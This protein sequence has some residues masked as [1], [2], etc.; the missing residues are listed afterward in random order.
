MAAE[1]C[2]PLRLCEK[3]SENCLR[4]CAPL[5]LCVFA[6]LR[7]CD[8]ATC[9]LLINHLDNIFHDDIVFCENWFVDDARTF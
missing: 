9:D 2:A 7:L 5:R 3:Q 8:L 4:L 1:L 6:T